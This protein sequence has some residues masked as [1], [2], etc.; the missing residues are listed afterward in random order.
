MMIYITYN[1][2]VFVLSKTEIQKHPFLKTL[3]STH[4]FNLGYIFSWQGLGWAGASKKE[5]K[6]PTQFKPDRLWLPTIYPNWAVATHTTPNIFRGQETS[7][8]PPQFSAFSSMLSIIRIQFRN[9]LRTL[10]KFFLFPYF[11]S[12]S[13]WYFKWYPSSGL[14][15]FVSLF[16]S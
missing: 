13:I 9:S 16:T 5:H 15:I 14:H 10:M 4:F 12:V 1:I 8:F 2:C 3:F 6:H 11:P 7:S